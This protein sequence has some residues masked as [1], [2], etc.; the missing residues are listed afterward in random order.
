MDRRIIKPE[1]I[2]VVVHT[3]PGRQNHLDPIKESLESSDVLKM[4]SIAMEPHGLGHYEKMLHWLMFLNRAAREAPYVLRL[5]DDV[6]VNRHILHNVGTW[7][8]LLDPDF[9]MGILFAH[10]DNAHHFQRTQ[11]G[12]SASMARTRIAYAQ[13]QLFESTALQAATK[14]VWEVLRSEG[15]GWETLTKKW[16]R[17]D[18][19]I[20]LAIS[21]VRKHIY[22]HRP[23]LVEC[24]EVATIDSLNAK[25]LTPRS[26]ADK[27]CDEPQRVLEEIPHRSLDFEL[28][29]KR[30]TSTLCSARK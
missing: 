9:G 8:A 30:S 2:S 20:S 10:E 13:G 15:H 22:L 16:S 6:V 5:E 21:K 19:T 28:D 18:G 17:F 1:Q 4:Y 25:R 27:I 26:G 23:S 29:W 7:S 24:S 12:L 11:Y 3:H 14:A